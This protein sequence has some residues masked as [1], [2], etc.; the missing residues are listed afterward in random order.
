M[1]DICLSRYAVG[2]WGMPEPVN[3]VWL[4][5]LL[6]RELETRSVGLA[7]AI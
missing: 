1:M 4:N 7:G 5:A 3:P 2:R 6:Y